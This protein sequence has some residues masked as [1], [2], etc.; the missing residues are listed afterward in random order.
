MKRS[1]AGLVLIIIGLVVVAL[2]PIW[3]WGVG[4][5]LIKLPDDIDSTSIYEGVLT[6]NVVPDTMTV[7]P[8]DMAIKVPLTITRKNVSQPEISDGSTAIVKETGVAKG[9]GGE[10]FLS[11]T[12]QYALD[13][14]TGKNVTSDKADVRNRTDY[15]I[16]LGFF[17]D[18]SNK[19]IWN[20]DVMK[21]GEAKFVKRSTLDGLDV[22]DN[23]VNVYHASGEDLVKAPP[24]GLPEKLSGADIKKIL[25]NPGLPLNDAEMYPIPYSKA[26]DA[27]IMVDR[28]VGQ[29]VSVD[30]EEIYSVDASQFGMGKM[31]LAK[32]KYTQ[33]PES[34]QA[35]VD[36]AA[37]NHGLLAAVQIWIPL[38][39]LIL[40]L[41]ILIIGVALFAR[42]KE[43]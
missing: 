41:V 18:D 7:L 17:P 11:Y 1:K 23:E 19:K 27:T 16:M 36:S 15:S 32:L 40:G 31:Q 30:M 22:K 21:A 12:K 24:L 39:L 20:D 33:T 38:G 29:I 6:L 4:P 14:K 8:P 43:A 10:D 9:P 5:T 42:T 34:V 13:R 25:N 37:E 26:T 28:K 2:A 35:S 3:K